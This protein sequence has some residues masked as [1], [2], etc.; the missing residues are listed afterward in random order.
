MNSWVNLFLF[1][2]IDEFCY[3]VLGMTVSKKVEEDLLRVYD[4]GKEVL[5]IFIRKRLMIIEV[6]FYDFIFKLKLVFFD[7]MLF[8]FVKIGGKEVMMK[9]DRDFFVRF[10]VVV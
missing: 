3:F 2:D 4:K 1:F 10:F 9:A 6:F 7:F 5:I 8:L